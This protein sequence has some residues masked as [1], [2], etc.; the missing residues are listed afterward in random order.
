MMK[1]FAEIHTLGC[2]L[3]IADSA[4]L[5]ARLKEAGYE[6]LESSGS[7]NVDLI[8]LNSCAVT[9][10]AAA[11]SRRM[12]R[13]MRRENPQAKIIV[14]GCAAQLDPASFLKSGA[15]AALPNG[16]KKLIPEKAFE[17]FEAESEQ[18]VFKEDSLSAFPFRSRAFIKIQEGCNNFC[19]YCIVPYVRGRERSR[20]FDEVVADCRKAVSDGF[21]ELVLTGVNTCAYNDS[22]RELT[23]LLRTLCAMPGEFRIRLSSTEPRMDNFSMIDAMAEGGDKVCRFLHLSLQH[24]SDRILKRMNRRYTCEEYARFVS[25]AR[26]KLPGVHVGTDV[27]AGFPGETDEDFAESLDFVKKMAF[28][29]IHI[30]SDSPRPGTPAA[31]MKEQIPAA[32]VKERFQALKQVAGESAAEFRKSQTGKNAQVI[33]E[34]SENGLLRGWSDNYLPFAVPEGM[35]P[36]GKIVNFCAR[37]EYFEKNNPAE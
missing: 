1:K 27:I 22:G 19:T 6:L 37:E 32:V 3:N 8:V 35:F 9:A 17:K 26:E 30:F 13:R 23:A 14:T 20:S 15:D 10:E 4:L 31:A 2:R 18:M 24:G 21:P 16:G 36:A 34:R 33:F 28:A 11:K 29:N 7:G 12:V 25:A 5:T